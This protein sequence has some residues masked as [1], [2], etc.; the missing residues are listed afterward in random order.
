MT[1]QGEQEFLTR[2]EAAETLGVTLRTLDRYADNGTLQRYRRGIGKRTIY[3][4]K[5]DVEELKKIK[6]EEEG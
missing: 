4:L 6:P 5:S 1:T 2:E 3:F